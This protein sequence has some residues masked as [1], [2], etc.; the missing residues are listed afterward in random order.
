MNLVRTIDPAVEPLTLEETKGHLRV[1]WSDEDA[2]LLTLIRSAR[3]HAEQ[4]L[5]RALLTQTW[6]L[7][8]DGF[9]CTDVLP[10]PRPTLQAVSAF[11]YIDTAGQ[12]QTVDSAIYRVDADAFPGRIVLGYAQVWP[13]TQA[14]R[15]AVS[16]TYTAGYGDDAAAVPDDI[17]AALLLLIGHWYANRESVVTGTI[18]TELPQSARSLLWMHR[19]LEAA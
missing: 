1:D 12:Q 2:Y 11:T 14:V 10:L 6:R 19:C 17:R 7:T 5:R 15:N 18:A 13:F 3:A 4:F 9:P 8:L 16:V